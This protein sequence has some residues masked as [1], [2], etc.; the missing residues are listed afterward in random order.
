MNRKLI[1]F[2]LKITG[3]NFKASF[4]HRFLSKLPGIIPSALRDNSTY[5]LQGTPFLKLGS[6]YNLPIPLRFAFGIGV[7]RIN[8]LSSGEVWTC[9]L[10]HAKLLK[11][12]S[13]YS[14]LLVLAISVLVVS[15]D[16]ELS[17]VSDF[18]ALVVAGGF[19]PL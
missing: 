3:I 8:K 9:K 18:S 5:K 1:Y 15:L 17:L 6:H 14:S 11:L 4:G 13:H 12:G 16:V 7:S 10:Q 2:Y 19:F